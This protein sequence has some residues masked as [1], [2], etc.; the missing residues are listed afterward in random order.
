M[1]ERAQLLLASPL[2]PVNRRAALLQR[3]QRE[4]MLAAAMRD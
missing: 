4:P 1:M 2:L 3:I